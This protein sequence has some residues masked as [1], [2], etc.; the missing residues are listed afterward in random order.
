MQSNL[1]TAFK[2]KRPLCTKLCLSFPCFELV[3]WNNADSSVFPERP[4]ALGCNADG[5][6]KELGCERDRSREGDT[7][8][9]REEEEFAVH[10]GTVRSLYLL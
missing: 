5:G 9:V 3:T 1:V 6:G 8:A 2:K 4:A 10:P 7:R